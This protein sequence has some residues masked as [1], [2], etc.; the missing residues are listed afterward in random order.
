[1][2][3]RQP[4]LRWSW[5]DVHGK[6]L[7]PSAALA[8]PPDAL[9][10]DLA[11]DV[12]DHR[13][14]CSAQK[15]GGAVG[16]LRPAAQEQEQ[17]QEQEEEAAEGGGKE[18][19]EEAVARATVAGRMRPKAGEREQEKRSDRGGAGEG[20]NSR[21][22]KSEGRLKTGESDAVKVERESDAVKVERES[23]RGAL[24]VER[25]RQ[26]EC[27][28]VERQRERGVERQRGPLSSSTL[29]KG[30]DDSEGEG[31]IGHVDVGAR[32]GGGGKQ[33]MH[34][35]QQPMRL[36]K[37]AHALEMGLEVDGDG[38]PLVPRTSPRMPPRDP[39]VS[40]C[41]RESLCCLMCVYV[42]FCV[43]FCVC[44]CRSVWL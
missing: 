33:A 20:T 24:F 5:R 22:I 2:C 26:R 18:V 44:R 13:L 31:G 29:E 23:H 8:V 16:E 39:T 19:E 12:D 21:L 37:E 11:S 30:G 14:A 3:V 1:M 9:T 43:C 38:L 41:N 25:E 34:Q 4:L 7:K 6:P 32:A 40:V 10:Y 42:C 35:Q 15:G 17:E 28:L 36:S 27:L